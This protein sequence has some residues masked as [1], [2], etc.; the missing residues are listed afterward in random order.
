MASSTFANAALATAA[1][2]AVELGAIVFIARRLWNERTE[3]RLL[4]FAAGV[5]LTT[6]SRPHARG[7]RALRQRSSRSA[8]PSSPR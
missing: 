6:I 2:D 5:L 4:T 3:M 8:S 7:H 1:I